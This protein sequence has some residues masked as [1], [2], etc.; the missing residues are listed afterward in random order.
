MDEKIGFNDVL[1]V[2]KKI[3]NEIILEG[4]SVPI[5]HTWGNK[6]LQEK[7]AWN[8]DNPYLSNYLMPSKTLIKN[9]REK[10]GM[11]IAG[12]KLTPEA[13]LNEKFNAYTESLIVEKYKEVYHPGI[14][15]DAIHILNMKGY[16]YKQIAQKLGR[17]ALTAIEIGHGHPKLYPLNTMLTQGIDQIWDL[18]AASDANNYN[19]S[20]A[21]IG[22][23]TGSS[24]ANA[25]QT[26]LQGAS[27]DFNAMEATYPLTNTTKRIDFKSSWASGDAE[28]HWQ[29]FTVDNGNSANDNLNRIVSDK[30][31]KTSGET[32]TAE[33]RIT[34][35]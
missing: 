10:F 1:T 2:D 29:E 32:W 18:I 19:N 28:F 35:S 26:G 13:I 25:T 14:G 9:L 4:K 5:I 6:D 12:L 22:V 33:I 31:T 17:C 27:T 20:N 3:C 30:G 16:N 7:P 23:G 34:G 11:K 24:A 15:N 8:D 21:R